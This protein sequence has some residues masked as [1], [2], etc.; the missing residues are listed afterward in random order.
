M[1]V[2]TSPTRRL[3]L[4][5]LAAIGLGAATITTSAF[6]DHGNSGG[7]S[8]GGNSGSGGGN[9]GSDGGNSGSGSSNS[10]SQ[11]DDSEHDQNENEH[12]NEQETEN[13]SGDDVPPGV[14]PQ[15]STQVVHQRRRRGR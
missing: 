1:K 11:H 12:E 9:S 7:G 8:G 13:E 3:L 4:Q 15:S 5:R 14:A 2:E 10:G 6:A